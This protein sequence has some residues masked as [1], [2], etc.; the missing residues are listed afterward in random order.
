MTAERS[1]VKPCATGAVLK[2]QVFPRCNR[3]RDAVNHLGRLHANG[4]CNLISGRI[5]LKSDNLLRG[6]KPGVSEGTRSPHGTGDAEHEMWDVI[7]RTEQNHELWMNHGFSSRL[8]PRLEGFLGDVESD[9]G[10]VART[11][12]PDATFAHRVDSPTNLRV[13]QELWLQVGIHA[14]WK[15]LGIGIKAG[16]R[17]ALHG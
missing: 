15:C 10:F 6:G 4:P 11:G 2:Y 1:V 14:I 13:F 16:L 5:E 12:L 17:C 8:P 3:C 7:G 9:A